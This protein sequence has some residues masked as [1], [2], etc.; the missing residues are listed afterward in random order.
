MANMDLK[1]YDHINS[2]SNGMLFCSI[3]IEDNFVNILKN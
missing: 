1:N 3:K 2:G